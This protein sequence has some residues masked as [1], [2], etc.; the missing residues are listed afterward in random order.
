[1]SDESVIENYFLCNAELEVLSNIFCRKS[2]AIL[3]SL[4]VEHLDLL[5]LASEDSNIYLWGFDLAAVSALTQ[6][7]PKKSDSTINQ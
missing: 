6:L 1:M 4:Y 5:V 3:R 7:T 2:V